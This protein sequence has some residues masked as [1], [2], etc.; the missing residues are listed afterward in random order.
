MGNQNLTVS[1]AQLDPLENELLSGDDSIEITVST[2]PSAYQPEGK[3][4]FRTTL[5]S[6]L[7]IYAGRRNNPNQVTAEQVN[8]YTIEQVTDLLRDKLG[9][10]GV[11]VNALRLDG[12]TKE[13]IITEARAG[14]VNDSNNL[15]GKPASDY[16]TNDDLNEVLTGITQSFD[17]LTDVIS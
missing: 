4:T 5:N 6:V 15:G 1:I 12:S 16:A 14:T 10:D 3:K 7:A 13:E 17:D 11:A 9:V 2:R 8:S